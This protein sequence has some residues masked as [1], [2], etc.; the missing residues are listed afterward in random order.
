[1]KYI[2]L[3]RGINVGGHK[4]ILMANL[5]ALFVSL[6][7]ENVQT[8][9]QSGNV[10][11][12]AVSNEDLEHKIHEALK[13]EYGWEI[14]VFVRQAS[15]LKSILDRCPFDGEKKE[16]CYFAL[17]QQSPL[18]VDIRD[19]ASYR[20]PNDEFVI[21]PE[22]VYTFYGGGQGKTKMPGNFFE[23]KLKVAVTAR[24]FRTLSK[25]I[26]LAEAK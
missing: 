19:A 8:Y 6:G 21:T 24:N 11:F 9:I 26:E 7:F 23:K 10:V 17:L 16:K 13:K 22:C 1:M 3:L 4:K 20:F 14:P 12:D 5:K 25:L 15:D 2:A 18:V